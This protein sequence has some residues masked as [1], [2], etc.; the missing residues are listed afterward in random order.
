MS[1][2]SHSITPLD[3]TSSLLGPPQIPPL[4]EEVDPLDA[5]SSSSHL[6]SPL[7]H[8]DIHSHISLSFYSQNG[9]FDK[10]SSLAHMEPRTYYTVSGPQDEGCP[11][12]ETGSSSSSWSLSRSNS[13]P[14]FHTP[15]SLPFDSVS[16]LH[17]P[18]SQDNL[19]L[20]HEGS[21]PLK[22]PLVGTEYDASAAPVVSH[23]SH[24]TMPSL[25][26]EKGTEHGML[27][28]DSVLPKSNHIF[29]LP[30]S[31]HTPPSTTSPMVLKTS[32]EKPEDAESSSPAP[33]SLRDRTSEG[34][35]SFESGNIDY[36]GTD[37]FHSIQAHIDYV[38]HKDEDS[39]EDKSKD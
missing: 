17:K 6:I 38:L 14:S 4:G 23:D 9:M 35:K 11:D 37:S 5:S 27:L 15:L 2:Y 36:K 29:S 20:P 8:E 30:L 32:K 22:A 24:V 12:Y 13:L 34:R 21:Y 39:K 16:F 31:A 18:I 28:S 25:L 19:F 3:S 33:S 7:S 26:A 10:I 1:G